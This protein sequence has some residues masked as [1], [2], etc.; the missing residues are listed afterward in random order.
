MRNLVLWFQIILFA[1]GSVHA[2]NE[3]L[4]REILDKA[5]SAESDSLLIFEKGEIIYQDYFGGQDKLRSVQ[6][7]TKSVCALA[8]A[9]LID[10]EKIGSLDLPMSTWIP[11]W[12]TDSA[13]SKITLRM[14]MN[15]TSGLPDIKTVEDFWSQIDIVAA[16]KQVAVEAEPG[17]RYLYSNVATSLLEPVIAQ[18]SDQTVSS[19]VNQKI[20]RPLAIYDFRW[21]KDKV[22][23]EVTAGGLF[24]KTADLLKLGKLMLQNGFY[25]GIRVV[26]PK[27]YAQLI[28]PSQSF[29]SYG[30]LFWLDSMNSKGDA[31]LISA[32]GWGGQYL[33]VYPAKNLIAIRTKSPQSI[34]EGRRRQQ[35][36]KEFRTLIAK[37]E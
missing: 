22:G 30:L 17:S 15:H 25:D 26:Q 3:A 12:K 37:W 5:R 7:I 34:D 35:S 31:Q 11:E 16:A 23:H 29:A 10:E 2:G 33:T 24:L 1:G 6:S 32:I 13:K 18:A 8:I 36:F 9:I 20:F 27:T 28:K 21:S 19:Y 14:I 4:L